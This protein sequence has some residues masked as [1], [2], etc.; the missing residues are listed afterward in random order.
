MPKSSKKKPKSRKPSAKSLAN[1]KPFSKGVSGNPGGREK[2]PDDIRKARRHSNEEVE[3]SVHR[4]FNM[5]R[6]ELT[7]M[8][9]DQN[10][11]VVDMLIGSIAA[12]AIATACHVRTH[13]LLERAGCRLLTAKALSGEEMDLEG[14]SYDELKELAKEALEVLAG[15]SPMIDV[16]PGDSNGS[17]TA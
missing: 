12:R 10:T 1:L 14:L 15:G 3:R 5:T 7:D 4:F 8:L 2:V 11:P 13:F 17:Q 16:T 9:N 6:P